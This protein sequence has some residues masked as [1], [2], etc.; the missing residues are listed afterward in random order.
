MWVKRPNGTGIWC[1]LVCKG[2]YQETTDKDDTYANT[3]L[4]ISLKLLLLIGLTKN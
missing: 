3:P 4:F 1:R 2:R